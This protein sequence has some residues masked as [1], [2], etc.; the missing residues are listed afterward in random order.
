MNTSATGGY[1]KPT[2]GG[3]LERKALSDVFWDLVKGLTDLGDEN[4]VISWPDQPGVIPQQGDAYCNIAI[5]PKKMSNPQI[6]GDPTGAGGLGTANSGAVQMLTVTFQF[7]DTGS[8]GRAMQLATLLNASLGIAQ[9]MEA[10]LKAKMSFLNPGD[11]PTQIQAPQM[12]RW[13]VG[14]YLPLRIRRSVDFTW[15]I[16]NIVAVPIKIRPDPGLNVDFVVT[17]PPNP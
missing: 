8:T 6:Q 16:R 10:V 3:P 17:K 12:G 7:F 11:E 4:I 15:P 1:I 14:V 5:V 2:A 9:N 13:Q